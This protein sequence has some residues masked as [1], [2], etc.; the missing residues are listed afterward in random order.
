[1]QNLDLISITTT[2]P[3]RLP[4]SFKTMTSLKGWR[5]KAGEIVTSKHFVTSRAKRSLRSTGMLQPHVLST[6][7]TDTKNK[8]WLHDLSKR[9]PN[10]R[11]SNYEITL[12][13][14]W[15]T[16]SIF[17]CK[18]K[19]CEKQYLGKENLLLVVLPD[20]ACCEIEII[21]DETGWFEKF[22]NWRRPV[23]NLKREWNGA[24]L[25][26][27]Q[28]SLESKK[29]SIQKKWSSTLLSADANRIRA[30]SPNADNASS[31]SSSE[32][33]HKTY[34][35]RP[36][37]KSYLR[38]IAREF[39]YFSLP[40]RSQLL[41]IHFWISALCSP[42]N[43]SQSFVNQGVTQSVLWMSG[44]QMRIGWRI[45]LFVPNGVDVNHWSA[46]PNW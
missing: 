25:V 39:A 24:F 35:K 22:G 30:F 26:V 41:F 20:N 5:Y 43:S 44:Q 2:M 18:S 12:H 45:N 17:F 3:S 38:R 19:R 8:T 15:T 21:L 4:L 40:I 27:L 37:M 14:T 33:K 31:T 16:I 6:L 9:V 34:R 36:T 1:M 10:H 11:I 28:R 13:Q 42:V 32:K 29:C 7:S 23:R 46:F